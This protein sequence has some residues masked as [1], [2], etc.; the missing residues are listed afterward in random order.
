MELQTKT[1]LIQKACLPGIKEDDALLLAAN[2]VYF[3]RKALGAKSVMIENT[4]F[5]SDEDGI[6]SVNVEYF[7]I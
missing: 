1:V 7:E 6:I 3:Q 4:S 5:I 2:N